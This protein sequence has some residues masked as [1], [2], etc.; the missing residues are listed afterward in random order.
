[1]EINGNALHFTFFIHFLL[2]FDIESIIV[3]IAR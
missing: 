1:M 3:Y 2:S